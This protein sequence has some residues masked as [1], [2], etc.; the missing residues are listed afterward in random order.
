LQCNV[1]TRTAGIPKADADKTDWADEYGFLPEKSVF[2]RQLSVIGV[3]ILANLE[4]L[5]AQLDFQ[6]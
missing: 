6:I 4:L 2:F 3:R 5:C 1:S